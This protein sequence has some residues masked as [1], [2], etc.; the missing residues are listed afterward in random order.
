[1]GHGSWV[2]TKSAQKITVTN[3]TNSHHL[4]I[5]RHTFDPYVFWEK[6][7][8]Q[9]LGLIML[10]ILT[11]E[12]FG[13]TLTIE[14]K[15]EVKTGRMASVTIK[16][17][18]KTTSY[19]VVPNENLDIFREYD[20]DPSVIK[21]RLLS[22][23][24][25]TFYIVATTTLNDKI[26]TKVCTVTVGLATPVPPIPDPPDTQLIRNLKA[27]YG[28]DSSVNK[29]QELEALIALY[30]QGSIFVKTRA[31]LKTYG[32]VWTSFSDVAKTLGCS[33]KL[34]AVQQL[35]LNEMT[36]NGIPTSPSDGGT[37]VDKTK[38]VPQLQRIANALKQV[39]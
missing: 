12:L 17:D 1:M 10:F 13:Q 22:Y 4:F 38:L 29:E 34:V 23:T 28:A 35:I 14:D 5:A 31:D 7:V 39:K 20:P 3:L 36:L 8:K 6:T 2:F 24:N 26:D 19:T 9:F 15:I 18:G 27:T 33:K 37:L 30:D 32:Q 16:S 25:G 11:G 21:L